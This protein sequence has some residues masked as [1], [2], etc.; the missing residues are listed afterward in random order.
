MLKYTKNI[1]CYIRNVISRTA[2]QV[3]HTNL[4]QPLMI[5]R[6]GGTLTWVFWKVAVSDRSFEACL[7]ILVAVI[8][9]FNREF[10]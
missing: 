8:C 7:L 9:N 5:F 1:F 2:S 10:V 6:D 3:N 4:L